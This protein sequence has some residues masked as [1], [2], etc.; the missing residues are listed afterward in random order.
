MQEEGV[1][2]EN[3]RTPKFQDKEKESKVSSG[4]T[5]SSENET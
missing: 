3:S 4:Q 1:A 2:Q 5:Q